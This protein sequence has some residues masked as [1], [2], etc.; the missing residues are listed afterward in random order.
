MHFKKWFFFPKKKKK[1]NVETNEALIIKKN[2]KARRSWPF[3]PNS[4]HSFILVRRQHTSVVR[5]LALGGVSTPQ[6]LFYNQ[7]FKK[8]PKSGYGFLK[9][10]TTSEQLVLTYRTNCSLG[11]KI[12]IIIIIEISDI[13]SLQFSYIATLLL[14]SVSLFPLSLPISEAQRFP[15]ATH[16][17]HS[18][19]LYFFFLSSSLCCSL[20]K[21]KI[22]GFET[23]V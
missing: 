17:N 16:V 5:A 3:G 13:L 10:F 11:C 6:L 2:S 8:H 20:P 1:V 18:L 23:L 19:S 15:H 21:S 14:I 7:N 4:Q 22:L 12:N 9:N